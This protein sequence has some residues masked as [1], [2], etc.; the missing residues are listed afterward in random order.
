MCSRAVQWMRKGS[1]SS[2]A[3][4]QSGH[5]SDLFFPAVWDVVSGYLWVSNFALVV[6]MRDSSWSIKVSIAAQKFAV[7]VMIQPESSGCEG[8]EWVA[9]AFPYWVNVRS[10]HYMHSCLGRRGWAFSRLSDKVFWATTS[11]SLLCMFSSSILLVGDLVW[12]FRSFQISSEMIIGCSIA[13][14]LSIDMVK[15]YTSC[16]ST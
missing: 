14:S 10:L 8:L 12:I 4:W 6:A 7:R 3:L 16:S 1:M 13:M 2:C 5:R 11:L 9:T 15:C